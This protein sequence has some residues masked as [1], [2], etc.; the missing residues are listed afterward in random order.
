[1]ITNICSFGLS[2]PVSTQ[3]YGAMR[4][5]ALIKLLYEYV[6]NLHSARQ[7]IFKFP[8]RNECVEARNDVKNEGADR[9][10]VCTENN[11]MASKYAKIANFDD[12]FLLYYKELDRNT[13]GTIYSRYYLLNKPNL[14]W[15]WS[16]PLNGKIVCV[17]NLR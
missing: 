7:Y 9:I 15:E 17:A 4:H 1:M 11:K 8:R 12:R 13:S 6:L 10:R 3:R 5:L 14:L 2:T 16:S